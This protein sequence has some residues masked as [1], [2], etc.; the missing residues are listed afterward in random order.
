[1]KHDQRSCL[2]GDPCPCLLPDMVDKGMNAMH[3]G[4]VCVADVAAP[5][6]RQSKP[7]IWVLKFGAW[8]P[9][10]RRNFLSSHT[11]ATRS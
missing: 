4:W 1:M 8:N 5:T 9:E 6:Q 10:F 2:G 11:G 7:A 3:V